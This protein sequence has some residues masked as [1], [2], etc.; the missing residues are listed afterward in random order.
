ML[1]RELP[2][3]E[4]ILAEGAEGLEWQMNRVADLLRKGISQPQSAKLLKIMEDTQALYVRHVELLKRDLARKDYELPKAV[5][6]RTSS[7]LGEVP[8]TSPA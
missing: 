1:E 8:T 2:R 4:Q 5:K 6:A 7:H 3:A